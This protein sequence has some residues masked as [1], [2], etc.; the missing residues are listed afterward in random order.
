MSRVC[1]F[2]PP[3]WHAGW[4]CPCLACDSRK[5]S[6]IFKW[7]PLSGGRRLEEGKELWTDSLTEWPEWVCSRE[8][9]WSAHV[10]LKYSR[11]VGFQRRARACNTIKMDCCCRLR[12]L[13]ELLSTTFLHSVGQGGVCSTGKMCCWTRVHIYKPLVWPSGDAY[14]T[15]STSHTGGKK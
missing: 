8:K 13:K 4:D 10:K 14:C 3:V 9:R 12:L 5:R 1:W 6:D 2:S 11:L 15:I 7:Q